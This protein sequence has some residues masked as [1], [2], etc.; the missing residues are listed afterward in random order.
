MPPPITIQAKVLAAGV[1]TALIPPYR[2]ARLQIGNATPDDLRVYSQLADNTQ[3]E[4]VVAGTWS[5]PYHCDGENQ[6]SPSQFLY[7]NAI[8]GGTVRLRWM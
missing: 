8:A 6:F 3:Y 2:C 7:A 5:N 1:I 4:V